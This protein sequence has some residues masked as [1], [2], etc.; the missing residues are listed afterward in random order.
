[1]KALIA[2]FGAFGSFFFFCFFFF[3]LSS[4]PAFFLFIGAFEEEASFLGFFFAGF[5]IHK[6]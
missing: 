4:S 1:M 5:W 2:L 3:V 6:K